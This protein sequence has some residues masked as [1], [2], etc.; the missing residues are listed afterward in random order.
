M[1]TK[2]ALLL[3]AV[4]LCPM[5]PAAAPE[6]VVPEAGSDLWMSA[7][8]AWVENG[9]YETAGVWLRE[10]LKTSVDPDVQY[11][12]LYCL[13]RQRAYGRLVRTARS[14]RF[15]SAVSDHRGM[16]LLGLTLW[17]LGRHANAFENFVAL[18]AMNPRDELAWECL[19][20]ALV[21]LDRRE[22]TAAFGGLLRALEKNP[23]AVSFLQ[24]LLYS[25]RGNRESAEKRLLE[26]HQQYPESRTAI[27]AIRDLYRHTGDME[28]TIPLDEWLALRGE[29]LGKG[30]AG[31]PGV[32]KSNKISDIS[33]VLR[34]SGEFG[35]AYR[36]PWPG[37]VTLYCASHDGALDT[38][39]TGRGQYALDFFLP[40]N[41][42]VLTAR[43]GVVRSLQDQH[44]ILGGREFETF[45]LIDHGDGTFAR[46]YH[47][48]GGTFRVKRGQSVRRGEVLGA[49]G[50]SG[51][52]Q[53]Q[54]LHFEVLRKAKYQAGEI[55]IYRHWET[56]PV[57]FEETLGLES[58]A[59]AGRWIASQ[60][61]RAK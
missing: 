36:L 53:S 5:P 57:D 21:S 50:R 39:H 40:T 13:Y 38:P 49:P 48:R 42:A 29:R 18:I 47:L 55:R 16:I 15:A 56:V 59:I 34:P 12:Y 6:P 19:H 44:K 46:Y 25:L 22:R 11:A 54:H 45:I 28:K 3:L 8:R 7:V 9:D 41:T 33:T 31:L 1:N 26:A 43:D 35:A 60:N 24:G 23:F 37:G 61:R 17:R 20:T 2:A 27:R 10:R 58:K 14:R 32:D 51:R 52:C 4:S 30:A